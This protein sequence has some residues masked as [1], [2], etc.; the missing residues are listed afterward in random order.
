MSAF[1]TPR[2]ASR[3]FDTPLMVAEAKLAAI[4]MGLGGRIVDGSVSIEG[5]RLHTVSLDNPAAVSMG[6]IGDRLGRA[7]EANGSRGFDLIEGVAVICVEGTLVHKGAYVGQSSGQTSYQ[8]IQAQV[9]RARRDPAVRGVA[10]E[11]DSHGGEADGA[12]ETADMIAALSRE[13][14]TMAILTSHANSA[15]Y[16]LAAPCRQIVMPPEGTAG[17]IGALCMLADVRGGLEQQGVKLTVIRAGARKFDNHPA[18]PLESAAARLQARVDQVRD[19]FATAVGRYRGGRFNKAQAMLTEAEVFGGRD[20]ARIGLVD[21]LAA[22][23]DAFDAF[24]K[25]IARAA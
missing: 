6:R 15:A 23:H 16:L 8:G 18:D 17:S 1:L 4:V 12:F 24:R 2:V 14:P 20:A 3:M 25:A 13:K 9:A 10:F 21:G 11:I 5:P 19:Q 7:I 22:G